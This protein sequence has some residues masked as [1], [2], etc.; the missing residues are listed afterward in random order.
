MSPLCE[1]AGVVRRKSWWYE[2]MSAAVING[3]NCLHLVLSCSR[4][5]LENCLSVF[6]DGDTLLF[7]DA[8][9]LHL[10]ALAAGAGEMQ[11][12]VF[13]AADLQARGLLDAAL[14][15]GFT[16]VDDDKFADLLAGHAHCLSW[17]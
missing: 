4:K 8:G 6:S 14:A 10:P 2:L 7:L 13:M 12:A 15:N 5:S 3:A 1:H 16:A 9:A 17:K 11:E